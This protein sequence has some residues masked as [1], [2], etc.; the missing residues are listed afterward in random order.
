MV[1]YEIYRE[2]GGNGITFCAHAVYTLYII[3]RKLEFV[4]LDQSFELIQPWI[5]VLN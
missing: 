4:T 1:L 5:R 3:N 2:D